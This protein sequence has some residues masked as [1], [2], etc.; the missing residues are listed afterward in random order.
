MSSSSKRLFAFVSVTLLAVLTSVVGTSQ[1]REAAEQ[2]EEGPGWRVPRTMDGQPDM[3]G[4]WNYSTLTP[5]ERP[6]RFGSRAFMTDAEA[7]EIERQML[8]AF[9][10]RDDTVDLAGPSINEFWLERG[11]LA[12]VDGRRPTSLIVDPPDGRIPARTPEARAE[13]EARRAERVA[14]RGRLESYTDVAPSGRCLRSAAGPPYLPGAP[15]ANLIRIT[16]GPDQ[17]ALVQ[18]KFHET[19]IVHLDRGPVRP[20]V[21]PTWV[22]TSRGRWEDDTLIVETSHFR[23]QIGPPLGTRALLVERF[24]RLSPDTL[25]YEFTVTDPSVFEVPWTARLPM[26]RTGEE[27][28][29][30]ACHEGNYG[31]PNI[32]R[33]ARHLERAGQDT[34]DDAR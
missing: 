8:Q 28:Y 30:F 23:P 24:T 5:T 27:L 16:Q 2:A 4:V 9:A 18:E 15:D 6:P 20:S 26:G 10:D 7:A 31:L 29:E 32:L 25:M 17:I 13:V 14:S 12:V 1:T 19:R 3:E 11:R 21:L 22:G 34:P 33:V